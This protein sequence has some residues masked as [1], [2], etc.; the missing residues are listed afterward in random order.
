MKNHKKVTIDDVK[1]FWNQHPLCAAHIPYPLGTEEYFNYYDTLREANESLEFSYELHEYKDFAG[2]KVLD[3]GSGNG[4][5]LS[6]YAREGAEVYGVDITRTAVDLCHK[7][8]ELLGLRGNFSVTNAEVLPFK[9]NTF[10]CVC[11]MGVLHHTPDTGKAVSEIHRVLKRGGRLIVMFYNRNSV[12]Y[13]ILFPLKRILSGK[14]MQQIVNELDGAGNP[15]GEVYSKK[16]LGD[17]LADYS[18]I[19]MFAG[20]LNLRIVPKFLVQPLERKFGFFLY[21]KG[22]KP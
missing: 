4:Y 2:K 12:S 11:S 18:Q 14:T 15:K 1:G 19:E 16:E 5:V 10:D 20:L 22:F 6:K 3:V 17:L 8:F 9:D 7:R 13:K 21:A